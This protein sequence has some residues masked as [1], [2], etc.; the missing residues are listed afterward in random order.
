MCILRRV[1]R[2]ETH[3]GGDESASFS[4]F[5]RAISTAQGSTLAPSYHHKTKCFWNLHYLNVSNDLT[6][7]LP[8]I[9][10]RSVVSDSLRPHWLQ[11]ARLLCPWDFPDKNTGVG[12]HFLLQG[13]FLTWRSH[14]HFLH[15][16]ADSLP[17][18]YLESPMVCHI[19]AKISVVDI[20]N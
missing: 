9:V 1:P 13:M 6:Y 14:L 8:F 19:Q 20:W 17:L 2:R 16:Q 4:P 5:P 15:G 3:S 12:C 11:P 10:V 7:L 18:S